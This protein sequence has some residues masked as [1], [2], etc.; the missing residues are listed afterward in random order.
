[1]KFGGGVGERIRQRHGRDAE[2][3][4]VHLRRKRIDDVVGDL[5]LGRRRS[6]ASRRQSRAGSNPPQQ[7]GDR[8][9]AVARPFGHVRR[10]VGQRR[11][12]RQAE[13]RFGELEDRGLIAGIVHDRAA[14]RVRRDQHKRQARAVAAGLAVGALLELRRRHVIV[15]TARI[16]PR[17]DDRRVVPVFAARDRVDEGR[18]EAIRRSARR[19]RRDRDDRRRR[20]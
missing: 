16:V 20:R 13:E 17:D 4:A 12:R 10:L 18:D 1:M 2:R 15:V 8:G 14:A 7:I 5:G 11:E 3:P 6:A 19:Y 9:V